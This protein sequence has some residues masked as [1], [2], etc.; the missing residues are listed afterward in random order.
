MLASCRCLPTFSRKAVTSA[1]PMLRAQC[2]GLRSGGWGRALAATLGLLPRWSA[3]WPR[4]AA[5]AGGRGGACLQHCWLSCV[6]LH[7]CSVLRTVPSQPPRARAPVPRVV[8]GVDLGAQA[9]QQLAAAGVWAVG[10]AGAA[11]RAL[12]EGRP[13]CRPDRAAGQVLGNPIAIAS[14]AASA[15]RLLATTTCR[16][17]QHMWPLPPTPQWRQWRQ[18]TP[19]ASPRSRQSAGACCPPPPPRSRR[20]PPPPPS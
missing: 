1:C 12:G 2:Q 8:A 4:S 17:R 18:R 15:P 19:P 20:A 13:A 3:G 6:P 5:G 14:A 16:A 10:R 7:L 9:Q 11:W